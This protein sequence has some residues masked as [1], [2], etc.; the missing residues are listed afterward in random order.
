MADWS[1]ELHVNRRH[2]R[3]NINAVRAQKLAPFGTRGGCGFRFSQWD[4]VSFC[5]CA[6]LIIFVIGLGWL[7]NF[8]Y[9]I[10]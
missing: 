10:V 7:V 9:S 2:G 5:A 4:R 1:H 3:A 8:L 6:F